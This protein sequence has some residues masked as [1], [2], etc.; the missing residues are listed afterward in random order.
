MRR[1]RRRRRVSRRGTQLVAAFEGFS[2]RPYRDA[3]GVW[4][5]GYGHTSGVGRS[6]KPWSK[7]RAL[8]VLRRE[9]NGPKYAGAVRALGLPL[10]QPMFDAIVSAVYNLG[11]GILGRDRSLGRALRQR[12]W[13]DAADALLLYDKAGNPP[14]PLLGL[15]RRRQRERALFLEKLPGAR[16][17]RR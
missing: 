17:T 15:T 5:I 6:S 1:P 16:Q 7:R 10:T 14:R 13:H 12:H 3:V 11:P 4:T 8:R 2:S 9:L